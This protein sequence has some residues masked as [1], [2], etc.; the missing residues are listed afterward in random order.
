[1]PHTLKGLPRQIRLDWKKNI[2]GGENIIL[3]KPKELA[4]EINQNI[5]PKTDPK[6]DSIKERFLNSLLI[7]KVAERCFLNPESI[8]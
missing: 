8:Q 4:T 1:M 6:L 2:R 3:I 5:K 7:L